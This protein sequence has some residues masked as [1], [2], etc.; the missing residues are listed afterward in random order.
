MNGAFIYLFIYQAKAWDETIAD[1]PGVEYIHA[2]SIEITPEH[3]MQIVIDG[4]IGFMT[5][6]KIEVIPSAIKMFM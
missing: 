5:P 6:C 3:P 2:K 1:A 4:E